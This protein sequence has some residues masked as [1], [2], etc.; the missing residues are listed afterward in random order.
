MV[1]ELVKEISSDNSME[2]SL[3]ENFQETLPELHYFADN[4]DSMNN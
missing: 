1:V 2:M 3:K 4:L